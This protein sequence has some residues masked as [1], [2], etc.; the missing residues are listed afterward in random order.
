MKQKISKI[1]LLFIV[2]CFYTSLISQ[3]ISKTSNKKS[4]TKLIENPEGR[5]PNDDEVIL[6][7]VGIII[8]L[9]AAI[10]SQPDINSPI[11]YLKLSSI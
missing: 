1:I 5:L 6:R 11:I 10:Y 9:N 2:L 8:S 3:S 4:P 7:K